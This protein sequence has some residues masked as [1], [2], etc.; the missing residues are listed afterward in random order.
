MNQITHWLDSS[1][2]YDSVESDAQRLRSFRDGRLLSE[3]GPD[4]GEMMINKG[5]SFLAGMIIM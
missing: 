4:G 3:I 2:V 1:N 5:G